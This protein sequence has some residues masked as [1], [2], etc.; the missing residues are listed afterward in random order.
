VLLSLE[1]SESTVVTNGVA[2]K[3]RVDKELISRE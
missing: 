3:E 2:V 1:I